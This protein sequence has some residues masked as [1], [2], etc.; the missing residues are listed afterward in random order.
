M[1]ILVV[2]VNHG[3]K[4]LSLLKKIV[5][6]LQ[7]FIKYEVDIYVHSNIPIN[8]IKDVKIIIPTKPLKKPK[9][10]K[11]N[12]AS[13]HWL[14]WET[15][16][17]IYDNKDNYDL[18][19]YTENDHLFTE[20][21]IDSYLKITT[22]LPK[23]II[24]GFMRIEKCNKHPNCNFY[25]DYHGK[26]KWIIKSKKEIE[27]YILMEFSNKHQGSF[28]L[29]QYQLKKVLKKQSKNQFLKDTKLNG[30]ASPKVRCATTPY[31]HGNMKKL[32]PIS[33]L[34]EFS[35]PH[36]SE[37]YTNKKNWQNG[38]VACDVTKMKK[39]IK[40]FINK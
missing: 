38:K 7:S 18:F 21:H 27:E 40:K 1:K 34:S 13:R 22:N 11:S 15:R 23:N 32:I 39:D 3:K 30:C 37:K 14:P 17:T 16:K 25:P 31:T 24:A 12:Y 5:K 6:E 33:H 26:K 2:I 4:Q 20:K 35:L 9:I 10:D 8:D 36:L 28:L 19:L 29:T